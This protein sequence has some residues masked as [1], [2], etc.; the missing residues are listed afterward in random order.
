MA[1]K[2]PS[3]T[4]ARS[5]RFGHTL[6]LFIIERVDAHI[7]RLEPGSFQRFYLLRQQGTVGGQAKI[8]EPRDRGKF[9]HQLIEIFPHQRL[10]AGETNFLHAQSEN[11][12]A[13]RVISSKVRISFLLIHSYSS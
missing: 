5:P 4:F 1:A 10:A 7:D 3:R 13:S 2:I 12:F 9:G 8:L 11:R 6:E